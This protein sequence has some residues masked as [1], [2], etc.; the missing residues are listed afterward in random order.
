MSNK[1]KL[2]QHQD[3]S[4]DP[5]DFNPSISGS[6]FSNRNNN[7]NNNTRNMSRKKSSWSRSVH[8][9]TPNVQA[10]DKMFDD[11][12]EDD[13]PSI[14]TMEGICA[15]AEKLNIDPME[16]IRI[17]VLLH[18]LG[19]KEKPG[20]I[21]REEWTKGCKLLQTDSIDKLVALLPSLDTGFMV[22]N[23]FRNFYKFCFQFNC[24]GTH[25]FLAKDLVVELIKMA[26]PARVASDR[27]S[28]F[29]TFLNESKD[30]SYNVITLDQWMSFFD[31]S[32]ECTDLKDY[33]EECSAWPLLIDDYV[34][35]ATSMQM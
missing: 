15:L 23:E 13:D 21:T 17:L 33:D 31:F 1:R 25:K 10:I 4:I 9:N 27:L 12:A 29:I 28:S 3:S 2:H 34:D 6:S 35:Y 8:S 24:E 30:T 11:I 14:A 18:K 20:Q 7:R 19:S 22:D 26:L 16:D 32:K 5:I